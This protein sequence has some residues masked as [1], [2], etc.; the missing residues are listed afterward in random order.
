MSASFLRRFFRRS[1]PAPPGRAAPRLSFACEEAGLVVR[2]GNAPEGWLEDLEAWPPEQHA[3]L[4]VLRQLVEQEAARRTGEG[5]EVPYR[6]LRDLPDSDLAALRVGEPWPY[7]IRLEEVGTFDMPS[8][9]CRARFLDELGRDVPGLKRVGCFFVEGS[10]RWL[11]TREAFELLEALDGPAEGDSLE[12]HL[13]WFALLRDLA[14][15]AG[16][17]LSRYLE[18]EEVLAPKRVDLEL[19]AGSDGSI[20]V[21]LTVEGLADG[22]ELRDRIDSSALI[23]RVITFYRPELRRVR[24]VARAPIQQALREVRPLGR[25]QGSEK[26]E[27]LDRPWRYLTSS[28]VDLEN[29]SERV[30]SAGIVRY[31]VTP[32]RAP[33]GAFELRFEAEAGDESD[34]LSVD[35]AALQSLR[36]EAARGLRS[37]QLSIEYQGRLVRLEP[38]LL[39][40]LEEVSRPRPPAVPPRGQVVSESLVQP[41][42]AGTPVSRE[43]LQATP[44]EVQSPPGRP[45]QEVAPPVR[46]E[47]PPPIQA[48]P[49]LQPKETPLIGGVPCEPAELPRSLS[50]H[51]QP[52]LHQLHG[53]AWLQTLVRNG[54]ARGALLADDMG[55]GKTLQVWAFLEWYRLRHPDHGPALLVVPI[56]LLDNWEEE[57]RK[58]FRGPGHL[59]DGQ[60]YRLHG[61]GLQV[62]RRGEGLDLARLREF[63]VVLTG[64]TTVRDHC[65]ALGQVR[66]S[67]LVADEAQN[68]KNP[69]T[70]T[71][72]AL[73]GL[74]AHFRVAMTGTPVEN[75]LGDLWSVMDFAARGHLGLQK[76]FLAAHTP[77]SEADYANLAARIAAKAS[78]SL[79]RRRKQDYLEGL[80]ERH[81]HFVPLSMTQRQQEDYLRALGTYRGGGQGL[82]DL[83]V[84][85]RQIC[86]A[87]EGLGPEHPTAEAED[88]SC[89][90]RW[91]LEKLR[92]VQNQGEKA[93]VFVE[94]R[95]LQRLLVALLER[96]F[97][98]PVGMINGEV[99]AT[100][101]GTASSPRRQ[102]LQRFAS[103]EGF[104]VLVLSPL[105][106][107]VGLTIVEANHVIHFTRHWNPAREDQATDRVYR[108]GQ[109]RPVHVYHPLA[110]GAGFKSLD[111]RLHE[112]LESKRR[113]QESALFPVASR[114]VATEKLV[115][116]LEVPDNPF[117][118][119]RW[120]DVQKMD[121]PTLRR[122]A[123]ALHGRMG[124]QVTRLAGDV[125]DASGHRADQVLRLRCPDPGEDFRR[126]PEGTTLVSLQPLPEHPGLTVLGPDRLADLLERYRPT[127]DDLLAYL[128]PEEVVRERQEP[129][130]EE[131]SV[132][133]TCVAEA[134][135]EATS[136]EAASLK[137]APPEAE[138]TPA[139]LEKQV[140]AP[141]AGPSSPSQDPSPVEAVHEGTGLPAFAGQEWRLVAEVGPKQAA[142]PVG[143]PG[144]V[145]TWLRHLPVARR[146]QG[147][148]VETRRWLAQRLAAVPEVLTRLPQTRTL[149]VL[150]AETLAGVLNRDAA[151]LFRVDL[152]G[153]ADA[154]LLPD[155][156]QWCLFLRE[157]LGE[158]VQVHLC[159]HAL[160]H[161]LLGHLRD[162]DAL[163]HWDRQERLSPP[164]SRWD[165]EAEALLWE[166]LPPWAVGSDSADPRQ[167]VGT[168][169]DLVRPLR[170]V[171]E[172]TPLAEETL[173]RRVA[174]LEAELLAGL[175]ASGEEA[176]PD[177]DVRFVQVSPGHWAHRDHTVANDLLLGA[178]LDGWDGRSW[179]ERLERLDLERGGHHVLLPDDLR[180][181]LTP[182]GALA[183]RHLPL[184]LRPHPVEGEV[185]LPLLSL[186]AAGEWLA[187]TAP[188]Q[189]LGYVLL[190]PHDAEPLPDGAFLL[191]VPDR[192][193][194]PEIPEGAL[195]L[196]SQ[197]P[198]EGL[199]LVIRE[200]VASLAAPTPE[201]CPL[202]WVQRR[203]EI[204][205]VVEFD[206]PRL[207]VRRRLGQAD[208]ERRL[209]RLALR[210]SMQA[211]PLVG[212]EPAVSASRPGPPEL[213]LSQD[214]RELQLLFPA[215]TFPPE[216]EL[217]EVEGAR[218][219]AG[220][221]RR[222]VAMA[223]PARDGVYRVQLWGAGEAR[224]LADWACPGLEPEA[225]TSF[226]A[227]AG[228]PGRRLRGPLSPG[229]SYRLV[230]P[231]TRRG[232]ARRMVRH[233]YA[234]RLGGLAG[235]GRSYD[236]LEL[237]VPRGEDLLLD[238]LLRRLGLSRAPAALEIE[239]GLGLPERLQEAPSGEVVP[240]YD[241]GVPLRLG[242]EALGELAAGQAWL[243][244]AGPQATLRH[245][246]PAGSSWQAELR[247]AA[248]GL[249]IAELRGLASD[250]EPA[251]TTFLL[252]T[253]LQDPQLVPATWSL[254]CGGTQVPP[255]QALPLGDLLE[256]LSGLD[257][258]LPPLWSLSVQAQG[259]GRTPVRRT[260]RAD[261]QGRVELAVLRGELRSFL[262]ENRVARITFSAGELGSVALLHEGL[263]DEGG[264]VGRLRRLAG[265]VNLETLDFDPLEERLTSWILPVLRTLGLE[266]AASAGVEGFPLGVGALLEGRPVLETYAW[267]QPVDV[268]DHA[269]H[270]PDLHSARQRARSEDLD[271]VVVTDGLCWA[272]QRTR[273]RL[274]L[275]AARHDLREA[276]AD[277]GPRLL[278]D[279]IRDLGG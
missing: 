252:E 11:L 163:G 58:F 278:L 172:L 133:G 159:L 69:A 209:Q 103:T 220:A 183:L 264:L 271:L 108:I 227:S 180:L 211:Q 274:G 122:F 239:V 146:L 197:D 50:S 164:L 57:Y 88:G 114:E 107:G 259:L 261:F 38:S 185:C 31:R 131:P 170:E 44:E 15:R 221:F 67:V 91:L 109:E 141:A 218:R 268:L 245:P 51:V 33:K 173:R 45:L 42:P 113:L 237:T 96:E 251:C 143:A 201:A 137:G 203:I 248:P 66:W 267:L 77:G 126:L 102:I 74:S 52:L 234:T 142:E 63:P 206:L 157:G 78:P 127:W 82:M 135:A 35:A 29:F 89:K 8:F 145:C 3:A 175:R 212:E 257:L 139:V 121:L 236:V 246:L 208:L 138:P 165:R 148:L 61:Q 276:F 32:R 2:A 9:T 256:G 192:A 98:I 60:I 13:E 68:I 56:G 149:P 219:A 25:L 250:L 155:G 243:L 6:D 229:R 106:A 262:A 20:Q 105:A 132:E 205:E 43:A 112:L 210:R 37:E 47:G 179:Q 117:G 49:P 202:A 272:I 55:L 71:T 92:Q 150:T 90:V 161:R 213:A 228:S 199:N 174:C 65:Q 100:S 99:L 169:A 249:W 188:L 190:E 151:N 123:C 186:T 275:S 277:P 34:S 194:E 129:T 120:P 80:P 177:E 147:D 73:H 39:E 19:E 23:P 48:L 1:E 86:C 265:Q 217:L 193:L 27:F 115:E 255:G 62:L 181:R 225:A 273:S 279:F 46:A 21:R 144:Q 266:A 242:L 156:R 207:A 215:R 4:L 154:A 253:P 26:R 214:G 101:T 232:T 189:P 130:G 167:G 168:P 76:E 216:A 224:T 104:S 12:D 223:V 94:Y 40:E 152:L 41:G 81:L 270:N 28:A 254:A 18:T 200:G 72:Q 263:A 125:L 75:G 269:D 191:E 5:L 83:L 184:R 140:A 79:L 84:R 153:E 231:P 222:P 93:L 136:E 70:R 195:L 17:R 53:I 110:I 260:M 160:A 166:P 230:T 97:G 22:G 128:P 85:L 162:G 178:L 30:R 87:A 119:I 116:I 64:Y 226:T 198:G 176:R 54:L 204:G 258:R 95:D 171:G 240:V 233:G 244:L 10:R 124:W 36:E 238:R 196:L 235:P 118:P 111:E 247:D 24:M 158:E 134:A 187:G 182:S 59:A 7:Q 14:L 241:G 16:A